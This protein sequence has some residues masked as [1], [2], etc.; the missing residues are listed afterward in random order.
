MRDS[1][2]VRRRSAKGRPSVFLRAGVIAAV[3]I[4][5]ATAAVSLPARATGT[6]P[7]SSDP[8]GP[9][10]DVTSDWQAYQP[11]PDFCVK[12]TVFEFPSTTETSTGATP[13]CAASGFPASATGLYE[14]KV[15]TPPLCNGCRRLFI[16]YS[17]IA[18]GTD[19]APTSHGHAYFRLMSFN[20]TYTVAAVDHSPNIKNLTNDYLVSPPGSPVSVVTAAADQYDMAYT[21]DTAN[22]AHT[23]AQGPY[24]V[25]PG[26]LNTLG[27]WVYGAYL[28]VN[29]GGATRLPVATANAIRYAAGFD[30]SPSTCPDAAVFGPAYTDGNYL[31]GGCVNAFGASSPPGID[32]W[33]GG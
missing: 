26:Y 21:G 22:Y 1:P 14:V 4:A 10:V 25:G 27:Q 28:D 30:S 17:K 2:S 15:A 31:Y 23:A 3:F 20:Q 13:A 9:L 7:T 16:D 6:D 19:A 8:L 33:P 32:P 18:P 24:Y 5:A 29:V 11:S 12:P